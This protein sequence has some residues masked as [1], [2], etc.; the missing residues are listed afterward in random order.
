M[1]AARN[2]IILHYREQNRKAREGNGRGTENKKNIIIAIP[3]GNA[4]GKIQRDDGHIILLLLVPYASFI[5]KY[6]QYY[7]IYLVYNGHGPSDDISVVV[8]FG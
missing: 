7:Y 4:Y 2:G 5:I 3:N 6:T 8:K 1:T